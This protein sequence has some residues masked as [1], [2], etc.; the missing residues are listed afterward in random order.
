M[1]KIVLIA[2]LAVAAFAVAQDIPQDIAKKDL[3]KLAECS[4]CNAKGTPMG[5]EKPAA[6]LMYKGHAY[7]V[8]NKAEVAELKKDPDAFVPLPLP[9]PMP[10]FSDTD[11]TGKTWDAEAMKG[12]LILVDYWAT[13]CGPCKAMF[14][15]L[16][17]LHAKYKER[18]FE[19]LSV[20]VDEKRTDLDKFLKG[21]KFPNPVLHDTTQT[22]AKWG[23]RNIPATFL[24]RDGQIVAQWIGKASEKDLATAIEA[25]LP[26]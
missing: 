12:K 5:E 15:V 16:D 6:G 1:K 8:C 24:V 11:T 19:L 9:R 3:P 13:W 22:F 17:K 26:K 18:G 10:E 4:V 7:Y 23:V 2:A 25:N 20:S 21:H 14:P